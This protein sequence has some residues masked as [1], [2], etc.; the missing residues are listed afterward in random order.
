MSIQDITKDQLR[1]MVDQ[2]GIVL[3]GCGGDPQEWLDGI[4]QILTDE[5][6][7]K[8][9]TRFEEAYTF[10]HEGFTCLLFPFKEGMAIEMGKLAV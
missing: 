7:L 4:N 10:K 3:Q 6:I 1:R 9:G 8:K 5:G 2:E